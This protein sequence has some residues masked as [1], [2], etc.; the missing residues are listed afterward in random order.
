MKVTAYI[1]VS[2][3]GQAEHGFGLDVQ[4][5]QVTEWANAHGHEIVQVCPD[6]IS[7]T[8][9]H[10][11][12]EGLTSALAA[13]PDHADAIVVARL[14]RLARSVTVQETILALAW[15]DGG[16]V[17]ALDQGGE[18]LRDD[19]DDPFRT[20]VREMAGVFAGLDRRLI[21]KRLRDGRKAKAAAGGHAVGRYPFGHD[22]NGP[23]ERE[24][25]VLATVKELRASDVPWHDVAAT[26]NTTPDHQP[27]HATAWT[28]A[29]ASHLGRKAGIS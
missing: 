16:R 20:A 18:V 22:K 2:T 12:R 3:N 8:T 6:E 14:D 23:V 21:V 13:L 11:D 25:T 27:R 10:Q 7:G 17:F 15:R 19:P 28:P 26:L 5:A 29:T 24:Q 1:R 9:D 4:L